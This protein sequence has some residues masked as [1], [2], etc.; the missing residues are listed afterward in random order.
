MLRRT[1]SGTAYLGPSGGPPSRLEPGGSSS[2]HR[3]GAP[4]QGWSAERQEGVLLADRL[5]EGLVEFLP[6]L[7]CPVSKG[8]VVDLLEEFLLL[9][10]QVLPQLAV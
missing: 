2:P 10:A 3:S 7:F 8:P 4:G 9:I 6:V 1:R 5:E